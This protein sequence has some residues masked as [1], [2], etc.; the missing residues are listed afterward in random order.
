MF[1]ECK[2]TF[3]FYSVILGFNYTHQ[4]SKLIDGVTLISLRINDVLHQSSPLYK[5]LIPKIIDD[6]VFFIVCTLIPFR[7]FIHKNEKHIKIKTEPRNGR[8]TSYSVISHDRT[9][10]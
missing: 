4:I 2:I 1:S 6:T 9:V 8:R 3:I 7:S 10:E 5:M